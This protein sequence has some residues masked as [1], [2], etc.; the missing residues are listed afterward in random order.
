[1]YK[2]MVYILIIFLVCVIGLRVWF[3]SWV[4]VQAWKVPI[5]GMSMAFDNDY[6]YLG[7][8]PPTVVEDYFLSAKGSIFRGLK[9]EITINPHV[10][11][12]FLRVKNIHIDIVETKDAFWIKANGDVITRNWLF[13]HQLKPNQIYDE[14]NPIVK[15]PPEET[16]KLLLTTVSHG[17]SVWKD[18]MMYGW[19]RIVGAKRDPVPPVS[20]DLPKDETQLEEYKQWLVKIAGPWSRFRDGWGNE[21]RL[22]IEKKA[23]VKLIVVSSAGPDGKWDTS[24]D[25]VSKC[26]MNTGKLIDKP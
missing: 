5:S 14:S 7:L 11:W 9:S 15:Q 25:L 26:D 12:G 20:F 19:P 17:T 18:R 21:I 2:K 6:R 1:M 8:S 16:T 13:I 4:H 3:S 10:A 22:E 23:D 24:D